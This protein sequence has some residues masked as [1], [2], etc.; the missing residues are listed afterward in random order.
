M[1]TDTEY[2][3]GIAELNTLW[4]KAD[5]L[6]A[7]LRRVQNEITQKAISLA[8]FKVG[9]EVLEGGKPARISSVR[10]RGYRTR[11]GSPAME[12]KVNRQ[13]KDGTYG[14]GEFNVYRSLEPVTEE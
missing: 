11:D 2:A 10:H 3:E 12:Y 8:P 5:E 13:K 9:D 14:K 6:Q 1:T 4:D 7:E